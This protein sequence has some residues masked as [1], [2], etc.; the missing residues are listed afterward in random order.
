MSLIAFVSKVSDRSCWNYAHDVWLPLLL[1]CNTCSCI[2]SVVMHRVC[3]FNHLRLQNH[4]LPHHISLA[5]TL[6]PQSCLHHIQST[7]TYQTPAIN[8]PNQ[9]Q[10]ASCCTAT[11]LKNIRKM[12]VGAV[13]CIVAHNTLDGTTKYLCGRRLRDTQL[14]GD[15][16]RSL[17]GWRR[18]STRHLYCRTQLPTRPGKLRRDWVECPFCLVFN[19][20]NPPE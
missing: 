8:N 7:Q 13:G 11:F 12:P 20:H 14:F 1:V 2:L 6:L 9:A 4:R 10:H 17:H 16:A 19:K 15:R 5:Q 3:Y 18:R